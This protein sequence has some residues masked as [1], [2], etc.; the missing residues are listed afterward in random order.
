MEMEKNIEISLLLDF[1][2]GLLKPDAA[3]MIDLYYNEDLSL[4]EIAAQTG[5]TR[6]GVRD[7]IKRCEQNLFELEQKLGMLKRFRELEQ[8]L[9]RIL[10]AAGKIGSE[11]DN[12]RIKDLAQSI[13][14]EALGLKE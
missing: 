9:D 2:G 8:G 6:Q 12:Q 14:A 11:T 10:E 3:Q 5:I 4:S 7:R 13:K 1:Y